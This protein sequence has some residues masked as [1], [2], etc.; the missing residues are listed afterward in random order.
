MTGTSLEGRYRSLLR[1]LPDAYRAE[2]EEEMVATF[3][4]SYGHLDPEDAEYQLE[5]GRPGLSEV[6]SV[7]GLAVRLWLPG[8]GHTGAGRFA[9]D[10]VR[11]VALVGLLVSA[12]T[13][14]IGTITHLWM[15]GKLPGIAAPSGAGIE[16]LL[17]PWPMTQVLLVATAVPAYLFL[18]AGRYRPARLLASISF[19]A[20]LLVAVN[21]LVA[22]YPFMAGRWLTFLL[23]L[24]VFAALWAYHDDAP[25]VARRRWLLALP[26]TIAVAVATMV[27]VASSGAGRWLVDW[28]TITCLIAAISLAVHLVARGGPEWSLALALLAGV[29][30]AERLATLPEFVAGAMPEHR[31]VVLAVGLAQIALVLLAGVPVALRARRAWKRQSV[32]A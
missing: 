32:F 22:G 31:A 5:F 28:P 26:A 13:A 23:N 17:G 20:V 12:A 21:D 9:G 4:A 8:S 19:A 27:A 30:L 11:L 1:I 18:V 2:W 29:V 3:L 6:A 7:A 10:A 16:P 24:L 14:T 15:I 25:P